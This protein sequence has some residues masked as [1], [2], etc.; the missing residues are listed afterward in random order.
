MKKAIG[1]LAVAALVSGVFAVQ[2]GSQAKPAGGFDRLTMLV[3]EWN[4]T[5]EGG[6]TFVST[7]RFVSNSTCLLYTSRCV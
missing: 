2:A 3:G 4:V 6:K 1:M 7:I 5:P